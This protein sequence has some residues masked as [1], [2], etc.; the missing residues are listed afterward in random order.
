VRDTIFSTSQF[1]PVPRDRAFAFF[2]SPRNL[3]AITPPWLRFRILDQSTPDIGEGT[4]F[5]YRLRLHGI[6]LTWKSRI[7]DWR[8]P[9]RFVDVQVRGPYAVWRHTHELDEQDGGTVIR[10]RVRY[11]LPL[12]RI[13]RLVAGGLVDADVRRIF[14]FRAARTAELLSRTGRGTE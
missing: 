9:E 2:S 8:P 7:A 10:D 6:P 13:G 11:R 3:E 5:T 12:G 1:V 4:E 14:A